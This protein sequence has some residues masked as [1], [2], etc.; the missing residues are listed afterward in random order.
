MYLYYE[1]FISPTNSPAEDV[2][3]V[4]LSSN[5][6]STDINWKIQGDKVVQE[7]ISSIFKQVEL[8]SR[9]FDAKTK[10]WTFLGHYGKVIITN[11]ESM[12]TQ[13]LLT[14]LTI[15]EIHD[16]E[17]KSVRARLNMRE[18]EES[19]ADNVKYSAEDFFHNPSPGGD[20]ALTSSELISRLSPLLSISREELSKES[21]N[22]K[23]KRI[24][25]QAALRLHPDQN[26]GDGSKMSELNMLW[27]IFMQQS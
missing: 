16:L 8:K 17:D 21:D 26:N 12:Q 20:A 6:A 3:S 25:R 2:Y 7:V 4:V 14:N 18:V 1:K 11:L 23:L 13:G 10:V 22:S 15:K 27:N 5:G 19:E 24:Y 9:V